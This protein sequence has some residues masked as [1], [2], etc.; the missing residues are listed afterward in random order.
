MAAT[1]PK[2]ALP[3][4]AS[5]D[6][7]DVPRDIQALATKLDN[8]VVPAAQVPVGALLLWPTAIAPANWL[9]CNGTQVDAATYPALAAVL[10]VAAGKITLPN[11]AGKFPIGP[12]GTHPLG[13]TGGAE[14]ATLTAAQMPAH[15]HVQNGHS[16]ATAEGGA[17]GFLVQDD[18]PQF[19]DPP[20]G[21]GIGSQPRSVFANTGTTVAVNQ[22]TGGGGSH[23]NMP[24]FVSINFIIRAL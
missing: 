22:N 14:T 15:T 10:P 13:Q 12:S 21:S 8:T 2:L 9:L 1:T 4:P 5:T 7:V 16:H 20:T 6:T 11:L 24:P 17:D 18:T 23:P 19:Y 3:Y